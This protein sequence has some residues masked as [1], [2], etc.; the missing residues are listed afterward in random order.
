MPITAASS[1][2][3]D[4]VS[5]S[6][7]MAAPSAGYASTR[8]RLPAPRRAPSQSRPGIASAAVVPTAFQY[9]NGWPMRLEISVSPIDAGH[10]RAASA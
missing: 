1:A 8:P 3:R 2:P 9:W 6:A 7:R 4:W 5:S 10:T